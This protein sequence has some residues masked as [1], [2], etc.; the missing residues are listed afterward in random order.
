MIY[1][2]IEFFNVSELE[3]VEGFNGVRLQ[4]FPKY[5]RESLGIEGHKRDD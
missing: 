4:R 3:Q 1:K 2:N 5:L